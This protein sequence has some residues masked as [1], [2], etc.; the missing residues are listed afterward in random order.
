MGGLQDKD[1]GNPK[2]RE[3]DDERVRACLQCAGNRSSGYDEGAVRNAWDLMVPTAIRRLVVRGFR[4]EDVEEAV[5]DAF[6]LLIE[7]PR[8]SAMERPFGML[9]TI[10][11]RDCVRRSRKFWSRARTSEITDRVVAP[12]EMPLHVVEEVGAAFEDCDEWDQQ[13]ALLRFEEDLTV[14]EIATSVDCSTGAVYAALARVRHA[15]RDAVL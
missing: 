4:R 2:R 7:D 10:A 9:L 5:A 1:A 6:V 13:V 15:V 11:Y 8:A 3:V 12:S 14:K